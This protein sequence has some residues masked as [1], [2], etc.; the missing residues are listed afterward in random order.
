MYKLDDMFDFDGDGELDPVERMEMYQ[1]MDDPANSDSNS[2]F[3]NDNGLN[4]FKNLVSRKAF[5][6]VTVKVLNSYE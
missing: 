6:F 3:E 4:L 2:F 5:G 1:F